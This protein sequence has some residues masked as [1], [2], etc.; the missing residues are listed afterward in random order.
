MPL[1]FIK[2]AND[3]QNHNALEIS[4]EHSDLVR[5]I[6]EADCDR[7]LIDF[8]AM[9]GED[10]VKAMEQVRRAVN[11]GEKTVFVV[12]SAFYRL[13]EDMCAELEAY[14]SCRLESRPTSET[15]LASVRSSFSHKAKP[16]REEKKRIKELEA[17]LK[18]EK[19]EEKRAE[20]KNK[21]GSIFSGH[22]QSYNDSYDD[23]ESDDEDLDQCLDY[24]DELYEYIEPSETKISGAE[25]D[26]RIEIIQSEKITKED[27]QSKRFS[28]DE[29]DQLLRRMD[30]PFTTLLLQLIDL[31]GMKDVE[32]YKKAGAS[33]QTWHKIISNKDYRPDRRTAISFAVALELTLNDTRHLLATVGYTLSKSSR[34]D[35]VIE[36][37]IEKG[38]YDINLINEALYSYDLPCLGVLD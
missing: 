22:L 37:F 2:N 28:P 24:L 33:R 1:R 29:L 35:I 32:C 13:S 30:V 27:I 17:Q 16:S 12:P 34:F 9:S 6:A 31:S 15:S 18:R 11:E 25:K 4:S 7:V 14:I 8:Y 20:R 10:Y 36:Y 21:G 23:Y 5:A 38:I 19:R 3:V 26:T